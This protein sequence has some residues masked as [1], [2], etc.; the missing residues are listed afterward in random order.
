MAT[1]NAQYAESSSTE[2]QLQRYGRSENFWSL[3]HIT[4]ILTPHLLESVIF[5][6]DDKLKYKLKGLY[7]PLI[8]DK[9]ARRNLRQVAHSTNI[10]L[11]G[12]GAELHQLN[13]IYLFKDLP[14]HSCKILRMT[15]I[16]LCNRFYLWLQCSLSNCCLISWLG[17]FIIN[18]KTNLFHNG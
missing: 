15:C 9:P 3:S 14:A 7:S 12:T 2:I 1:L 18:K 10:C 17:V 8:F 5:F 13:L 11:I 6:R 16:A 4:I